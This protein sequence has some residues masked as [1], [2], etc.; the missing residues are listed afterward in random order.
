[1]DLLIALP[2]GHRSPSNVMSMYTIGNT[3]VID[4]KLLDPILGVCA[5]FKNHATV[6]GPDLL[7]LPS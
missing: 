5:Q 4:P 1:M 7:N 3:V 6:G 2:T